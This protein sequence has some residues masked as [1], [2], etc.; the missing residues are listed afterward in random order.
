MFKLGE[1]DLS[2]STFLNLGFDFELGERDLWLFGF[3]ALES[4]LF[5][6][7]DIL[8]VLCDDVRF[9]GG[10]DS[11]SDDVDEE[12]VDEIGAAVPCF[13]DFLWVDWEC[14]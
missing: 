4:D 7:V 1:Y 6:T 10:D 2:V 8:C 13:D 11:E 9:G 12:E 5:L 3:L 14:L